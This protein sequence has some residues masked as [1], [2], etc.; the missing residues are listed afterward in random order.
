LKASRA[1]RTADIQRPKAFR[2]KDGIWALETP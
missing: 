1:A 2:R